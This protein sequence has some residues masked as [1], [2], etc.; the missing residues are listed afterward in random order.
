L[1]LNEHPGGSTSTAG[2][3]DVVDLCKQLSRE[4]KKLLRPVKN[5]A[6]NTKYGNLVTADF[7]NTNLHFS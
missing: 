6:A 3:T 7:T 1:G 2:I 5:G 4:L